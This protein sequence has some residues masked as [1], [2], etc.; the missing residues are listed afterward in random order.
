MQY[1]SSNICVV[2]PS[3]KI[4]L[5]KLSRLEVPKKYQKLCLNLI[6]AFKFK[7]KYQLESSYYAVASL[8]DVKNVSTWLTRVDFKEF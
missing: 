3:L 6:N 5:S 8:L 7:F 4:V 1:T 2:V